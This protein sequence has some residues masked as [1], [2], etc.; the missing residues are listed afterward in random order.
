MQTACGA[1]SKMISRATL[2]RTRC[3]KRRARK[4]IQLSAGQ[5]PQ[6]M[7]RQRVDGKQDHIHQQ[8]Q[9]AHADAKLPVKE[10]S[11]DR[12][13]PQKSQKNNR[14]I[15]EI[16]VHILQNE[17]ET[18]SRRDTCDCAVRRPRRPADQEKTPGNMLCGSNSR[19]REIPAA[20]Q[21]QKR[22]RKWPPVMLRIDQR[23]I[24][25]RKIRSPGIVCAF[26]GPQRRVNSKSSQQNKYRNKLHPPGIAPHV[27]PKPDSGK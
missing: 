27:L 22:G 4:T 26:E 1:R 17:R 2:C 3:A 13:V 24:K 9:R 23:R 12:V 7:A 19:W 25:R 15:Q 8:N 16:A 5:M 20:R 11:A 18:W 14:Q 10:E 6:G 21:N